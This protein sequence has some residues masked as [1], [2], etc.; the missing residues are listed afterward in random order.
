MFYNSITKKVKD[1]FCRNIFKGMF[2][3]KDKAGGLL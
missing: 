3:T 1:I 2:F